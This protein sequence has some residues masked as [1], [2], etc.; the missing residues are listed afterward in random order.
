MS[1]LRLDLQKGLKENRIS[2]SASIQSDLVNNK[3]LAPSVNGYT[4]LFMS[5]VPQIYYKAQC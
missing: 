5:A 3:I 4:L 1:P 2:V